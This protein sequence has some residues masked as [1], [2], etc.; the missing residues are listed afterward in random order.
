MPLF[1]C[2]R[3]VFSDKE[4]DKDIEFCPDYYSKERNKR[5]EGN[6]VLILVILRIPSYIEVKSYVVQR[7]KK[8]KDYTEFESRVWSCRGL[9]PCFNTSNI[10]IT[11]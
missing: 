3:K 10:K 7:V 6:Q 4:V 9:D 1:G 11:S 8:E 5:K 2:K